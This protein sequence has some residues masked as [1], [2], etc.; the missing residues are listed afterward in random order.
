MGSPSCWRFEKNFSAEGI[1]F[2]FFY[3]KVNAN[4]HVEDSCFLWRG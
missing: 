1:F 2:H 3:D 4:N